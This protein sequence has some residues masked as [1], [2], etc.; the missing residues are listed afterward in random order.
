[1]LLRTRTFSL[2]VLVSVGLLGACATAKPPTS[3]PSSIA[4]TPQTMNQTAPSAKHVVA[5]L[6]A[7]LKSER[8]LRADFYTEASLQQWFGPHKR[9]SAPSPLKAGVQREALDFGVLRLDLARLQSGGAVSFSA[10][11]DSPKGLTALSAD[12]LIALL[13]APVKQVDIIAEQAPGESAVPS[14]GPGELPISPPL[15][16]TRGTT[17]HPLGNRDVS[18]QWKSGAFPVELTASIQGDGTVET[19]FGQLG[20]P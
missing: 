8:M 10:V 18:W 4:S 6:I 9:S 13:G 20:T 17:T 12:D 11:G 16:R 1:M 15:L 5:Q 2:T 14:V 19:L 7:A 3:S